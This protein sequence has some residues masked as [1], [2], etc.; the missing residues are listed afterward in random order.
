M[1]ESSQIQALPVDIQ[2]MSQNM[3]LRINTNGFIDAKITPKRKP[4]DASPGIIFINGT[5]YTTTA[6]E[7]EQIYPRV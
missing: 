2:S 6:T 5:K 4:R 1:T 7:F 3:I